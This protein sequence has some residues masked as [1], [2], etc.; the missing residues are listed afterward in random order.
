MHDETKMKEGYTMSMQPDYREL[1]ADWVFCVK[2]TIDFHKKGI[3]PKLTDEQL[4]VVEADSFTGE[5]GLSAPIYERD[6]AP[7]TPV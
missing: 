7:L 2:G 6:Y 3:I 1:L 4:P 5:P